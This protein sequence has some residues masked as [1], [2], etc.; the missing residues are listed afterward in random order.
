MLKSFSRDCPKQTKTNWAKIGQK[1][2]KNWA[3]IGQKLGKN[4]AKIGRKFAQSGHPG[5]RPI[6]YQGQRKAGNG[7]TKQRLN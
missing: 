7:L 6:E 2:G 5:G 1:L 4:W 3:K